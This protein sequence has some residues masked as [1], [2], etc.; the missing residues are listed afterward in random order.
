MQAGA[1]ADQ[2]FD[3]GLL[4][5]YA[6]LPPSNDAKGDMAKVEALLDDE[7]AKVAR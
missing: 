6:M 5:V 2:G 3:P 7:L 4:T 1:F